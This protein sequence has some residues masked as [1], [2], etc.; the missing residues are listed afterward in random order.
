M[1]LRP[2]SPGRGPI[3]P[4]G[5]DGRLESHRTGLPRRCR[6]MS[7]PPRP[8][9]YAQRGRLGRRPARR[10]H[11]RL[12][13]DASGLR[14]AVD[15]DRAVAPFPQRR[16][17]PVHGPVR[18]RP[19]PRG[20]HPVDRPDPRGGP[21]RRDRSR[22]AGCRR[23]RGRSLLANPRDWRPH[24]S[25]APRGSCRC[26][27]GAAGWRVARSPARRHAASMARRRS[28]SPRGRSTWSGRRS[29]PTAWARVSRP[30][31]RGH[32][33]VPKEFLHASFP[34]R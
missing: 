19:A 12:R 7:R 25:D 16:R 23:S 6:R 28:S 17:L 29:G 34:R 27:T 9:P 18:A 10:G 2:L 26:R 32:D 11:G 13:Q 14:P 5:I 33:P 8:C 1:A 24:R 21:G 15:G 4:D 30:W 20:P 31:R 3:P 22:L